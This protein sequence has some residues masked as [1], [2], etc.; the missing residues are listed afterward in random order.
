MSSTAHYALMSSSSVESEAIAAVATINMSV[1][2]VQGAEDGEISDY[3]QVLEKKL[4]S[5]R[6]GAKQCERESQTMASP[7]KER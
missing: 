7:Y 4:A 1:D 3:H 2:N 6:L 5:E